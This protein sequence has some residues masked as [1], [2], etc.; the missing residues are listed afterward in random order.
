M[1]FIISIQLVVE[2]IAQQL[3]IERVK[4]LKII[5]TKEVKDILRGVYKPQDISIIIVEE[6]SILIYVNDSAMVFDSRE[7]TIKVDRIVCKVMKKW[8]LIVHAGYREK[9][10]KTELI[11]FLLIETIVR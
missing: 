7:D 10:F 1:K 9:K 2:D 8:E 5:I 3:K 11:F 4:I 6:I